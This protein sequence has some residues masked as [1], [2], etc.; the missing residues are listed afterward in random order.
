MRGCPWLLRGS[1]IG[2][3]HYEKRDSPLPLGHMYREH[4]EDEHAEKQAIS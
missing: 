3:C 1:T 4:M 2:S